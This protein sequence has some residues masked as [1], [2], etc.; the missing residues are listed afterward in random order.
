MRR[1]ERGG[2][3]PWGDSI[4]AD[5]GGAAP[6]D[7]A[8]WESLVS[9]SL[10]NIAAVVSADAQR[11]GLLEGLEAT[12]ERARFVLNELIGR[13]GQ[14][15]VWSAWQPSL[16]REV[17]IK[18]LHLEMAEK[19]LREA[20][21]SAALDHPNILPIYDIGR[22]LN[23]DTGQEE[24][25]LAMKRVRGQPW[26]ER[27]AR[28][29]QTARPGQSID[30]AAH[31]AILR[32]VA[33]AVSFA[34]A[35]G[36]V[37]RDLNP[38]QVMLGEY[39]EVLLT[40]WG[41][42][43]C[44]LDPVPCVPGT[45][46]PRFRP[47]AD[48]EGPSGTPAYMA[49]EQATADALRIG[50]AT[51]VYLLGATLHELLA[52]H[53][54]HAA[55]TPAQSLERARVNAPTP[56]PEDCP[57]A[58]AELARACLASDPAA[59][60]TIDT[61]LARLD[62][63]L[64]GSE[65][66]RAAQALVAQAAAL[67]PGRNADYEQLV[68]AERL[69]V[70]AL[71]LDPHHRDAR[72]RHQA[73]VYRFADHAFTRGDLELART[74]A[75]RVE[76]PDK[77]RLLM[78][79][80]EGYRVENTRRER[81]RL[82]ATRTALWLGVAL[83][84]TTGAGLLVMA[85]LYGRAQSASAETA[86]ALAF[87]EQQ[88][89]DSGLLAAEQQIA[90]NQH[91]EA[92]EG[93][94]QLPHEHRGPEWGLLMARAFPALAMGDA[95][96]GPVAFID[97]RHPPAVLIATTPNHIAYLPE[98]GIDDGRRGSSVNRSPLATA[99][100]VAPEH[101]VSIGING[102]IDPV[103][104][105]RLVDPL[106]G[107]YLS[108]N[109]PS[110]YPSG[111]TN[112]VSVVPTAD[113]RLLIDRSGGWVFVSEDGKSLG[114]RG[115]LSLEAPVV[116][117]AALDKAGN[118]LVAVLADGRLAR[119]HRDEDT[120]RWVTS[121]V[122]GTLAD[123]LAVS[124]RG[125]VA[126]IVGAAEGQPATSEPTTVHIVDMATG[127]WRARVTPN[128]FAVQGVDFSAD[129]SR[130]F[131]WH[132]DDHPKAYDASSWEYLYETNAVQG[133]VV[134]TAFNEQRAILA[135]A[136]SDGRLA[137]REAATGLPLRVVGGFPQRPSTVAFSAD[138]A[139]V[140]VGGTLGAVHEFSAVAD[141]GELLIEGTENVDGALM[142]LAPGG[143]HLAG[144]RLDGTIAVWD[145]GTLQCGTI[146]GTP[147]RRL[148]ALA[149]DP[150]GLR[151]AA[152]DDAGTLSLHTFDGYWQTRPLAEELPVATR[153]MQW[154]TDGLWLLDADASIVRVGLGGEVLGRDTSATMPLGATTL[155]AVAPN[156]SAPGFLVGA[157]TGAWW[158]VPRGTASA[159]PRF[160]GAIMAVAV[161]PTGRRAVARGD[162]YLAFEEPG[163]SDWIGITLDASNPATAMQFSGD[164]SRLFV[165][166]ADGTV[167]IYDAG[168]RCL[169]LTL[170]PHRKAVV[171]MA[172]AADGSALL[173]MGVD[174][175]L[176]VTPIFPWASAAAG[177]STSVEYLNE[178]ARARLA[179]TKHHR[180]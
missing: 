96:N 124:P 171:W 33:N 163:A 29:R 159:A 50:R 35:K 45:A 131:V 143:T 42:A 93:L 84:T 158:M 5:T 20:W 107:G 137:I 34:H 51:D 44:V 176:V 178:A 157:D 156:L 17:A 144:P 99:W 100:L 153:A 60:P 7:G 133:P 41:M 175:R 23:P 19:V 126:A 53:P 147:G 135:T 56:L 145:L 9:L 4:D 101:F 120:P 128:R 148:R 25:L 8:S 146:L 109:Q 39:G 112:V 26:A 166:R 177:Y 30:L 165:G 162:G 111:L 47:I 6:G 108:G 91:R 49:P 3:A 179:W 139:R 140:F 72:L 121:P 69:L 63:H 92:R 142:T 172:L 13:G 132:S 74:M 127:S 90:A 64:T 87:S 129:A 31:L 27:L 66:R 98:G 136:S 36:I 78:E 24:L 116:A 79:L 83:I 10:E 169:L 40:D 76:D 16:H 89:Y 38:R 70:R 155:T 46:I 97:T 1:R 71:E 32:A 61:F 152:I 104:D 15:E 73:V 55:A 88:R 18:R 81:Q 52:G 174:E 48:S 75:L 58:L 150:N 22:A 141:M 167:D 2:V 67:D 21:T 59:R 103:T 43:A 160:D 164:G 122:V 123:S 110:A 85:V 14:G 11:R 118:S 161:A 86:R 115:R 113:A 102:I 138:G 105:C 82:W 94:Y 68:E 80:H 170:R 106:T 62:E 77:R 168:R 114:A 54:P 134:A 65:Q 151:L 117:A 154:K 130:L 37:H 95:M 28:D 119:H 57:T 173:S 149:W 125:D 180:Q 12:G